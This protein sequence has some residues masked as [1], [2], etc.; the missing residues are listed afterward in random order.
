M[1]NAWNVTGLYRWELGS[2]VS[3]KQLLDRKIEKL[4]SQSQKSDIKSMLMRIMYVRYKKCEQIITKNKFRLEKSKD[5]NQ[6]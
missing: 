5:H 3:L 1:Q 2:Y 6:K 4:I